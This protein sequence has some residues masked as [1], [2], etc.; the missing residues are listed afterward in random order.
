MENINV[1]LFADFETLDAFGPVEI[2]GKL[3]DLYNIEFYSEKGGLIKSSQNVKVDTIAISEIKNHDIL[4]IPGGYGTRKEVKNPELIQKLKELSIKA[5]YVLTVCTGTAL[6]A[7]TG[8]LKNLKATSNKRA[9]DWVIQQ[10]RDVLWIRKA[11]WVNDDK[12]YTSSGVSA[13]MDMVLGFIRDTV[14][15]ESAEKI[16][17]N[18]EYIW[19]R[20]KDVDP[21]YNTDLI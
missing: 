2:L 9:F 16:A 3:N 15:L 8:L 5:K 10:D 12:F 6:L 20:D 11:R 14:G 21:F 18:I 19:N 13:G 7:K 17:K 4:L 1:I